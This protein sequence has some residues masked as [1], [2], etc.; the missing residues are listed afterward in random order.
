MEKEYHRKVQLKHESG[1]ILEA[2]HESDGLFHCPLHPGLCSKNTSFVAV[3]LGCFEA[4][5]KGT[6]NKHAFTRLGSNDNEASYSSS[7][8]PKSHL[9]EGQSD[10]LSILKKPT[11]DLSDGRVRAAQ[12]HL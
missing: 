10:N 6:V 11:H 1:E 9:K 4:S 3:H 8:R 5:A 12:Y 2:H 7:K